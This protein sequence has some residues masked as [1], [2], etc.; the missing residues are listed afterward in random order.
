MN[1]I[2]IL[3]LVVVACMMLPVGMEAKKKK[4]DI[5]DLSL[6]DNLE[7]PEI[8]ND[9]QSKRVQD[10]QYEVAV[11]LK[12][13]NYDVELMRDNEVIVVTLPAG[14]LFAPNDT[15]LSSLG[16]VSLKPLLNYLVNP[17]FY[18]ML[19]VMHSDNTGSKQYVDNLTR[20]RVNAVFDWIDENASV[21]FVVPYALGASDPLNDNNSVD[22]RKRNRRLEIYLVPDEVMIA[23]AKKGRININLIQ[24]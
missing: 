23:Q 3:I 13:Q 8:D 15:L 24:K 5:Y 7:T 1:K 16:Q 12:K 18:K 11:K 10:Y 20:S 6:D 2:H 21:D 14:Q 4:V 19:L 9:K 17:G 22:N